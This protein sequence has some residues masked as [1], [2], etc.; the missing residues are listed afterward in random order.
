MTTK[1]GIWCEVWGG[2]TGHRTSWLKNIKNNAKIWEFET[3]EEAQAMA[4][5][6]QN[7]VGANSLRIAEYSYT[8]RPLSVI[9]EILQGIQA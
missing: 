9:D 6:Y 7:T 2:V 1:F 4:T 8:V 5:H 3:E